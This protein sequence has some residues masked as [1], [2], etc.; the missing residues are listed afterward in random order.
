MKTMAQSAHHEHPESPRAIPLKLLTRPAK[1]WCQ[2]GNGRGCNPRACKFIGGSTPSQ[3]TTFSP[4]STSGEVS[5][6]SSCIDGFDSHTGHQFRAVPS[7]AQSGLENRGIREGD[8]SIPS[9]PA[10]GR[11]PEWQRVG[12]L[13]R[14]RSAMAAKVRFLHLPPNH[15]PPNDNMSRI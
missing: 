8:G 15:K 2:S 4:R 7:R 1:G 11:L 3:P 13:S 9:L 5:R 6:F 14:S 12:L 10:K